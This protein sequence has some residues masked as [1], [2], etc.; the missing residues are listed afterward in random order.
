MPLFSRAHN[1]FA[2]AIAVGALSIATGGLLVACGSDDSTATSNPTSS[3]ASASASASASAESSSSASPETSASESASPP[4]TS[5][6][7]AATAPPEQPQEVPGFPGPTEVPVGDA[8]AKFLEELKKKGITPAGDGTMAVGTADFICASKLEGKADADTMVFVTAM[9][10]SESSA[11]G[12]ELTADQAAADAKTYLDVA[13][14]T[15]CK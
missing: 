11:A 4:V 15:Y 9:V 1:T 3:A 13:H 14:A 6:G 8:G 5:P 7:E 2:R 12:E 10:G